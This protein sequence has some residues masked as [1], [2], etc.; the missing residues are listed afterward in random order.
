MDKINVK[1][2]SSKFKFPPYL[3]PLP[4]ETVSQYEK[5]DFLERGRGGRVEKI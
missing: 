3:Y 5:A 4:S 2:Q 1:C